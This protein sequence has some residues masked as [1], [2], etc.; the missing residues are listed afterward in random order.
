ML[1]I[2]YSNRTICLSATCPTHNYS[3]SRCCSLTDIVIYVIRV[4]CT[5]WVY[6]TFISC[7]RPEW[8]RPCPFVFE[9]FSPGRI[10]TENTS[11]VRALAC[12]KVRV[13]HIM[14]FYVNIA[15]FT[16]RPIL[17][18]QIFLF[19]WSTIRFFQPTAKAPFLTP[20]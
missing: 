17:F 4:V 19:C 20:G 11:S 8:S 18:L 10:I 14:V 16:Y 12:Y 15:L 6:L 7:H 3:H 1:R 5:N 2:G 13:F 9:A